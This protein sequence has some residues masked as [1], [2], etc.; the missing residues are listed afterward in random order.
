[1]GAVAI[2]GRGRYGCLRLS[3]HKQHCGADYLFFSFQDFIYLFMKNTERERQRHRQRKKQAPCGEPDE[4]LDPRT[5]GSQPEL[6]ADTQPLSHPGVPLCTFFICLK[7][8][9]QVLYFSGAERSWGC[10]GREDF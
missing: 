9:R 7:T 10:W 1:M 5:P 8:V 3:Y 4:G 2:G 6:K